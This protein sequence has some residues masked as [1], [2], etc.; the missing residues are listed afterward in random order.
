VKWALLGGGA[1]LLLFLARSRKAS[2][3]VDIGEPVILST[4]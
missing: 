2:L 4:K 1:L 3:E